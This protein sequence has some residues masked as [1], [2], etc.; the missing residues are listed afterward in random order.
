MK[1]ARIAGIL[2]IVL[3]IAVAALGFSVEG[4][5]EGD[6]AFAEKLLSARRQV[7]QVDS[8]AKAAKNHNNIAKLTSAAESKLTDA[9]G[10]IAAAIEAMNAL[11]GALAG[12]E[13]GDADVD[14]LCAA[15]EKLNAGAEVADVYTEY[16]SD[17]LS[18]ALDQIQAGIQDLNAL[19]DAKILA[20]YVSIAD[21]AFDAV[22]TAENA[23]ASVGENAQKVCTLTG[24]TSSYED[25]ERSQEGARADAASC[26]EELNALQARLT[27]LHA[28]AENI[29]AWT[30]E[31][32]AA[33][34]QAQDVR[35]SVSDRLII[36]L[37][38]NFIGVL[39][40]SALLLIVGLVLLLSA[41]AFK[42]RWTNDP[43]FSVGM[44]LLVM[45]VFQT[46]A[47][48]FRQ[49]TIGEWAKFWFDNTFNVLRANTSV[50]IVALGMTLVI[51]IG[52]IDLA[53]GS[54]L[55]GVGTV[56]MAMIDTGDHGVLIRMGITGT[57]AFII[58]ILAALLAGTAIGA[59]NGLLITKGKVPP[60][61]ATLGVMNIVRSVAQYFT[62]SYTPTVPKTFQGIA[63]TV[64]FGQRPLTILYW[65]VLAVIFYLLM[66][67]TAFGRYVYATGSNE[68]TTRLSGINTDKIKMK[69]YMI[70]GFVVAIAAVAQLSRLGG[71][72]V[73]SA[74][75][76]YELDSIAAVVVGGTAMSGGRGS[77]VGTILGVLIIGL[78]NNLLIL[79]GVDSFLTDAFKGA[80]VVAAVLM[81]RKEKN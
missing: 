20:L 40:T 32:N 6:G 52:G 70:T 27:N 50:G 15:L 48:G 54:T 14:A 71:M 30:E 74:G 22:T 49:N 65:L 75:N 7:E 38:D 31:A 77:I 1:K 17:G 33:V 43:V 18:Q 9:D 58:G 21:E 72:D 36:A 28:E 39:F 4:A 41:E 78:M 29:P 13:T 51:M 26:W 2:T 11:D 34:S 76:G 44:A 59:V 80:I 23:V 61:I 63:N 68:R 67:H 25:I 81:Q 5:K 79:L 56:L 46:Y 16:A 8:N 55:A 69:V 64:L 73:A 19:T 62:K 24:N 66:K 12:G 3:A 10:K 60:F 53:V 42:R 57:P 37:S 47:L 35:A 45:L